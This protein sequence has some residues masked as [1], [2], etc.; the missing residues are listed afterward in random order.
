MASPDHHAPL[1]KFCSSFE[2]ERLTLSLVGGRKYVRALELVS[3]LRERF[4][5]TALE[6]RFKRPMTCNVLV[7]KS[8]QDAEWST[9]VLVEMDGQKEELFVVNLE[10]EEIHQT[11]EGRKLP[12]VVMYFAEYE[13]RYLALGSDEI[14]LLDLIFETYQ[15]R[16]KVRPIVVSMKLTSI[17]KCYIRYVIVKIE[18]VKTH[19]IKAKIFANSHHWADFNCVRG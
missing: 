8:P 2:S 18:L 11:E 19:W 10:S 9:R 3:Q 13:Q 1:R 17:P 12:H 7:T 14:K 4:P 6:F 5:D 15:R 16:T